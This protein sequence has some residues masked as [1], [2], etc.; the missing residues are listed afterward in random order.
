MNIKNFA[1][2][3]KRKGRENL[4][5][6]EDKDSYLPVSETLQEHIL[7][8]LTR[9]PPVLLQRLRGKGFCKHT[10]FYSGISSGFKED[11]GAPIAKRLSSPQDQ[12]LAF[13][14]FLVLTKARST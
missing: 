2:R 6:Q 8:C 14:L 4:L 5:L 10:A 9:N 13:C 11:Y 1:T 12:S 7:R 3:I